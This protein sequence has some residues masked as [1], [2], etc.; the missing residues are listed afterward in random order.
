MALIHCVWSEEN[1]QNKT[2]FKTTPD[3][4]KSKL[5][6]EACLRVDLVFMIR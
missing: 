4:G 6:S 3:V 1:T 2:N 5:A